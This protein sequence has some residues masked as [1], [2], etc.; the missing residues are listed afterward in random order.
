MSEESAYDVFVRLHAGGDLEHALLNMGKKADKVQTKMERLKKAILGSGKMFREAGSWASS[1]GMGPIADFAGKVAGITAAAGAAIGGYAFG[2]LVKGGIESN[3]QMEQ[4]RN[5][6]GTTLQ[7]FHHNAEAFGK[8]TT[9]AEQFNA[10]LEEGQKR[11]AQLVTIAN[12]S[13]GGVEQIGQLFQGLLPGARSVTSDMDRIMTLTQ[14]ATLLSATLG[15]RFDL[16]GEQMSRSL[17]GGAG[18]EMD[19]FRLLAP[20]I[21]EAGIALG[22]FNKNQA[23]GGKLSE[24]FN[25]LSGMDRLKVMEEAMNSLGPEVAAHFGKS[26]DGV[27]GTAESNLKTLAAKFTKPLYDGYLAFASKMIA[28]DGALGG[29][30]FLQLQEAATFFG[31]KLAGAAQH[32]FDFTVRAADYLV[33][34]WSVIGDRLEGVAKMLATAGASMLALGAARGAFGAMAGV[35]GGI[36]DLGSKIWSIGSSLFSLG[37][38]ALIVAPLLIGLAGA[39]A[40]LSVI[41]GGVVAYIIGNFSDLMT[42]LKVAW[43]TGHIGFVFL[44]RAIDELWGKLQAVGEA[45]LGGGQATDKMTTLLIIGTKI[46]EGFTAALGWLMEF[47]VKA[48]NALAT[49]LRAVDYTLFALDPTRW[50]GM[51]GQSAAG[52]LADAVDTL[53]EAMEKARVAFEEGGSGLDSFAEKVLGFSRDGDDDNYWIGDTDEKKALEAPMQHTK[54][55][56]YW[57]YRA[58]RRKEREKKEDEPRAKKPNVKVTIIQYIKDND[59]D[60]IVAGLQRKIKDAVTKPLQSAFSTGRKA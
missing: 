24:A 31:T 33:K 38:A 30:K 16:V 7:L 27:M 56:I 10:N 54:Q 14:K 40:G 50:V 13:P 34:H 17:T 1:L 12:E 9:A 22:V 59:P 5:T 35:A 52:D 42:E 28:D 8:S 36:T 19:M 29:A 20:N 44:M 25:K 47:A 21:R 49:G 53:A 55:G 3:A 58:V 26:W 32:V 37:A 51:Y 11:M 2:A 39:M 15:N 41:F 4:M 60:A 57:G 23:M 6:I 48:T 18:S 45:F 46:V 43:E